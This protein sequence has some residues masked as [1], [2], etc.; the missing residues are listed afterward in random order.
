MNGKDFFL[1]DKVLHVVV[2]YFIGIVHD[3]FI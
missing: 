1:N 3:V 2:V